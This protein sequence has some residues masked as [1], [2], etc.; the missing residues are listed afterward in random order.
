MAK[1][2]LDCFNCKT[3][4]FLRLFTSVF[5]KKAITVHVFAK[6]SNRL[7]GIINNYKEKLSV[8]RLHTA[9]VTAS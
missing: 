8:P 1:G 6:K 3:G 4:D 9:A 2:E 5:T 7:W